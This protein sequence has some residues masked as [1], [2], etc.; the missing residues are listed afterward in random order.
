MN[1]EDPCVQTAQ[2]V[3][4]Q[5]PSM[6]K[7]LLDDRVAF[8]ATEL[9][10]PTLKDACTGVLGVWREKIL[11]GEITRFDEDLF[12]AE[13]TGKLRRLTTPS[14]RPVLNCTGVVVHTNLGRSCLAEEAV[15]AA[16]AAGMGYSTLEYDLDKGERGQRNAHVESLLCRLTGAEA[17]VVVN[18]NAAAVLLVLA[19]LA[20]NK[21]AVVSRG[22]LVEIGGSFRIPDIMRFAGT[23]LVETGC[24]N[25]THLRDYEN[26]IT[27]ETVMLLKVHPSNFRV[28]GFVTSPEREELAK[29]AHRR[30]L[31][32]VEDLGSGIL[33]PDEDLALEGETTVTE[34]LRGG[35]DLVTFSGDKILG[36]PQMGA[37][38]GKKELIDKL[39]RYP[40]LRALRCGK[41]TLAALEATLRMYLRGDWKKIPTLE[42]ITASEDALHAR[43]ERFAGKIA[44]LCAAHHLSARAIP[45]EDAVGGG[46]YPE[47]PLSGWAV[48][49]GGT[50]GFN[51]SALQAALRACSTPVVAP[52]K[53]GELLL[54]MRT[55]RTFE[56]ERLAES[57]SEALER[58]S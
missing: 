26:A 57:L 34:C 22:E 37:I 48:A 9:N 28:V 25:R 11:N 44:S 6:D 33:V 40:L 15:D 30:G 29:L 2:T 47:R 31:L 53:D 46:A 49:L 12:Y 42:M 52:V 39:R 41:M 14:L 54:H 16:A 19:A 24:T 10:R 7:L 8:F 32:L 23:R 58:I 13:I 21:D 36:G 3:L 43:A 20:A 50:E 5:L 17:A 45:C 55:I 18:N 51:P 4:R 1:I 38:V 35:V 56:E 27:D